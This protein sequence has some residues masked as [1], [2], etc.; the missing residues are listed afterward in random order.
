MLW[1]K[2][3]LE[4]RWKLL[5]LLAF[6]TAVFVIGANSPPPAASPGSKA[7]AQVMALAGSSTAL[8]MVACVMLAGTGI[9]TQPSFV[10]TKG[11]HGSTLFT[12]SLPVSRFRLLALRAS[13]GWLEVAGV[14]GSICGL[15]FTLP[16]MRA[17]VAP[18]AMFQFSI[19]LLACGSVIYFA[20]DRGR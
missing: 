16:L 17:V 6:Y 15:W 11:L 5:F 13:L 9:A 3:W 7:P 14:V 19:A 8:M 4:T 12:L 1:Y 10:V 20:V 2:G 18:L